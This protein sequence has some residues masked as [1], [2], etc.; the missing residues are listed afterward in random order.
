MWTPGDVSGS[1]TLTAQ[2]HLKAVLFN[3]LRVAID[4]L[5]GGGG[6]GTTVY[7]AVVAPSGGDYSTVTAALADGKKSI[8][9]RNGTYNETFTSVPADTTITGESWNAILDFAFTY[10]VE[11]HDN[12]TF[13]NLQVKNWNNT[14]GFWASS[15]VD[16]IRFELCRFEATT[17]SHNNVIQ[18]GFM[19]HLDITH[20]LFSNQTAAVTTQWLTD[21]T[22][23][24][25]VEA[26][27]NWFLGYQICSFN[28]NQGSIFKFEH[29]YVQGTWTG[30]TTGAIVDVNF[31][32]SLH[33]CS[34]AGNY[35]AS[36]GGATNVRGVRM[37]NNWDSAI[38]GNS[39][40]VDPSNGR[41]IDLVDTDS[42]L[43][44][45]NFYT[46]GLLGLV[47]GSGANRTRI[48]VN[49]PLSV[50]D[51]SVPI[52]LFDSSS[53][54]V[55]HITTADLPVL[56]AAYTTKG[57]I[58][59]RTSS[60][61]A[62]QAVGT[63]GQVLTADSTSSTGVS[64]Q[65][66]TTGSAPLE[67]KDEG[68]SLTV[69]ATSLNFTGGGVTATTVGNNVTVDVPQ[70]V[71]VAGNNIFSVYR[72]TGYNPGTSIQQ[73]PFDTKSYDPDSCFDVS[74]GKFT[75]PASGRYFFHFSLN[76][77]FAAGGFLCLFVNGSQVKVC[78]TFAGQGDLTAIV[79]VSNGQTVECKIQN[80]NAAFNG[81][82]QGNW[83]EGYRL[84]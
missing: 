15:G 56:A 64:Y 47:I 12:V 51:G 73:L 2:D 72:N 45:G 59:A 35:L 11:V 32:G 7:Q 21:A 70:N 53:T 42:I 27:Y 22:H 31:V 28:I 54:S 43:V 9:V 6:T 24:S 19:Y 57:D 40:A 34:I 44:D 71:T 33:D 23:Y 83:F 68:S 39:I 69:A 65:T 60:G 55:R 84:T 4:S 46:Q 67:V 25:I 82:S 74:T 77:N 38:R 18:M 14:K 81:G 5:P 26:S 1:Q 76:G 30:S 50:L 61:P 52:E 63:N 78:N 13:R 49:I 80:I 29:N 17:N 66:P 20:C 8:W 37:R 48:G 10:S 16:H 36:T 75:A 79:P 62:R 3:E 58:I 41:C